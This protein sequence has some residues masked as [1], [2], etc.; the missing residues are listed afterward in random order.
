MRSKE[1]VKHNNDW[2]FFINSFSFRLNKIDRILLKLKKAKKT[3]HEKIQKELLSNI[4]NL[5]GD[6]CFQDN[7]NKKRF[8]DLFS[9]SAIISKKSN[10]NFNLRDDSVF[11]FAFAFLISGFDETLLKKFIN[12]KD[13]YNIELLKKIK[14]NEKLNKEEYKLF[15]L[16]MYR[17]IRALNKGTFGVSPL[18]YKINELFCDYIVL[19]QNEENFKEVFE[20]EI[21]KNYRRNELFMFE[22]ETMGLFFNVIKLNKDNTYKK[23]A[24]E[25][26]LMCLKRALSFLDEDEF[27]YCN[28][29][30]YINHCGKIIKDLL[31]ITKK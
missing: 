4:F 19:N 23:L 3:E 13:F 15:F 29:Q 28:Q 11:E 18:H 22:P 31:P 1:N 7:I 24:S 10:Y 14:N 20:E 21:Q 30:E 25:Y 9:F 6:L 27:V 17:N 26:S 5:R 12:E 2:Y 16:K 8:V